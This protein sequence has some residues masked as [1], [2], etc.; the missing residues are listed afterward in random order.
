MDADA[1][2]DMPVHVT[3]FKTFAADRLTT[4]TVTLE[5]LR[6]RVLNASARKKEKLPWLKLAIF[7]TKRT[8]KNSLRNDANIETITGCE[9][10]YDNEKVGFDDALRAVQAMHIHA[11]L[12]TSPS[13]SPAAPRWRI[14]APTSK[15]LPPEMRAKLVARL[16]GSLKAECGIDVIAA[17][18]SFTLSQAYYY[19]W[20]MNKPELDHRAEVIAGDFIDERDDLE[21]FEPTGGAS[22]EKEAAAG[23]EQAQSDNDQVHGFD[24]ILT[25]MGDGGDRR[26]FNGPLSR[27]AASYVATYFE[28]L[29]EKKLKAILRDAIDRA[30]KNNT[31]ERAESIK[32]Y[33]SDS[34]LSDIINSAIKKFT[35]SLPVKIEHFVAD[36]A[37]HGYIYLPT[38]QSWPASSVNARIRP[39]ALLDKDG[40]PIL[41]SKK[42]PKRLPASEWLDRHQPIEAVTWS[43]GD[44]TII[45]DRLFVKGGWIDHAGA[46]ALNLYRPP[47]IVSGDPKDIGL[48]RDHLYKIYPTDAEH[49]EK[50]MAHRVQHP[51]VKINHAIFLGGDQGIGKDTLLEPLKRAV[52]PW[53]F[54]EVSPHTIA[55]STFNG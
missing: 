54:E 2:T 51:E 36:M 19:G 7:G 6:E 33:K 43:P 42:K 28:F 44:E 30:P 39:V 27:A 35:E 17:H 49:L 3:F 13:H 8:N 29:D 24:T 21:I 55:G 37:T 5:Q 9:L 23:T 38:R 40:R 22:S 16:N 4:E 20:V 34:Y 46:R 10:D 25:Q 14:L 18:E 12:Y 47:S 26:G 31:P 11:L 32:R 45:K 1:T 53:N 52:G 50:W 41:D 15:P 48:W